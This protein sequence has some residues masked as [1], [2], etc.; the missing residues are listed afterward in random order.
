MRTIEHLCR[1]IKHN[2]SANPV[3]NCLFNHT[4]I[5]AENAAVQPCAERAMYASRTSPR[6]CRTTINGGCSDAMQMRVLHTC[7]PA[8]GAYAG[9]E[10]GICDHLYSATYH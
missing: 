8:K 3:V 9:S 2:F 1:K 7:S 6:Q 5:A 10:T 4:Y